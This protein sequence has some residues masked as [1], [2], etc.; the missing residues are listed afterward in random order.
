MKDEKTVSAT[1]V[2][3]KIAGDMTIADNTAGD[4]TVM[5]GM[6]VDDRT[7]AQ[8]SADRFDEAKADA[9]PE[10]NVGDVILD[11]YEVTG[12]LGKGGMGK[13]Y[14]VHHRHW[15]ADLA[16][17]C[18]LPEIAATERGREDFIREAETWSNLGLHPNTVYCYYVRTLGDIPRVFVEVTI[19]RVLTWI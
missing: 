14:K 17:K 6:V 13:V 15:N 2:A 5:G 16:V 8:T 4:I 11:T 9:A 10:W 1:E 7:V 19:W 12:I 3:G 18:A